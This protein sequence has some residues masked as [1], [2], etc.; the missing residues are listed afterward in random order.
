M[1]IRFPPSRSSSLT[2][3][4]PEVSPRGLRKYW[5]ISC[6]GRKLACNEPNEMSSLI[7]LSLAELFRQARELSQFVFV[8]L[9]Q[10]RQ[11]IARYGLETERL[12]RIRNPSKYLGK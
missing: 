9:R 7:W 5:R 2:A 3:D 1:E 6:L 8:A 4:S 10:R 11:R 12:D